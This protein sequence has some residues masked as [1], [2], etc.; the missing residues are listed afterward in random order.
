MF[1]PKL[2]SV[3]TKDAVITDQPVNRLP[4]GVQIHRLA[5]HNDLRGSVTE[6]YRENWDLGCRLVQLNAVISTAGVLRGVH[7]HIRHVDHLVLL[8]GRM[9]L[10]LHDMRPS[11]R[12]SARHASS[13]SAATSLAPSSFL[14]VS[15]MGSIFRYHPPGLRLVARLGSL[16]RDR[17]PLEL[18]G[19]RARLAD[20][21]SG[22]V[23]ARRRS[24]GLRG[25]G[26]DL[27]ASMGGAM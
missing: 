26:R 13:S 2:V 3:P 17:L 16:G 27:R 21:R 23:R 5:P 18:P 6:L 12:R 24:A 25:R 15:R 11:R 9:V 14:S 7:V 10:G 20:E 8:A 19:A 4:D 1:G 22:A